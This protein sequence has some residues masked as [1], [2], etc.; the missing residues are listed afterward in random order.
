MKDSKIQVRLTSAEHQQLKEKASTQN[1]TV[2]ALI[3]RS[4]GLPQQSNA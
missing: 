4:V 2:A 3:R 1:T